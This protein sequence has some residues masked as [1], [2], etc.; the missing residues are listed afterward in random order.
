VRLNLSNAS[1]C[2]G[3]AR[4]PRPRAPRP[5]PPR[6]RRIALLSSTQDRPRL[7][8][9]LWSCLVLQALFLWP[10]NAGAQGVEARVQQHLEAAQLAQSRQD[11]GTA[12]REY[13]AAAHLMPA[14][15]ELWSNEGVA[16]YCAEDLPSAVAAFKRAK[17]LNPHLFAPHLFLGLAASRQGETAQAAEELRAALRLNAADPTAHLWLG[18]TYVAQHQFASAIPEFRAVLETDPKNADA[19]YA[20]GQ[21]WLEVGRRKAEE[22]AKIAPKGAFL[23]QLA[24]EQYEMTGDTVR[25]KAMRAESDKA[26]SA[27]TESQ[28]VQEQSVYHQAHEAEQNAEE[29]F[30]AVLR[31]DPNSYRAHQILADIDVADEKL[32]EAIAEY[33]K[34]LELNPDLP[35][36]HEALSNCLMRTYHSAEALAELRAELKLQPRSA[37]VLAELGRVQLA[38]GDAVAARA[39]LERAA[40]EP[41]PPTD[42][43]LLLGKLALGR[44]DAHAAIAA[45]QTAVRKDP[46]SATAYYLLS[47]AYRATGDRSAMASCLEQYKRFSE[48]ARER[49]MA[50]R[51]MQNPNA[52]PP[53]MDATDQKEAQALVSG[54][55]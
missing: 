22:L 2:R 32:E 40:Q 19:E 6:T 28:R 26:A 9:V 55:P 13:A 30:G 16:F 48:D 51:A 18:Y 29:A 52:P 53:V 21:C 47:R 24:A 1:N 27:G 23:L 5:R 14:S 11:C 33:R 34:V 45:L 42:A 31:D 36:V 49:E 43:Y 15:A 46:E 41:D 4:S 12:A 8:P 44:N 37:Q 7:R 54:H 25:A 17:S 3:L 20:L 38:L 35:G 39:S 10:Y 50:S